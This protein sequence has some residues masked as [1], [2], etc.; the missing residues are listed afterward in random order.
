MAKAVKRARAQKR[1]AR[2]TRKQARKDAR[3]ERRLGKINYKTDKKQSRREARLG[4]KQARRDTRLDRV[5][6]RRERKQTRR[7]VRQQKLEARNTPEAIAA[8]KAKRR[9][10]FKSVGKG[11]KDVAGGL[12]CV[13]KAGIGEVL[14]NPELMDD[15]KQLAEAV[16][17]QGASEADDMAEG[18]GLSFEKIADIASTVGGAVVDQCIKDPSKKKMAQSM[19]QAKD[20]AKYADIANDGGAMEALKAIIEDTHQN[21]EDVG[22]DLARQSGVTP[23][24]LKAQNMFVEKLEE[25]GVPG[26]DTLLRKDPAEKFEI[27]KKF[28]S[29]FRS[30]AE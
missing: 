23:T 28:I 25:K 30:A 20:L 21:A 24:L 1:A 14:K 4:R 8:R 27:A 11:L 19:I 16:M 15:V 5:E 17:S 3:N 26:L 13:G 29:M 9:K 6:S 18:D 10:F 22:S 7:D 12:L 2:H